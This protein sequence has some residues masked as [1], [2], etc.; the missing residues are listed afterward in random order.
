[1]KKIL[2]AVDFSNASAGVVS[3]AADMAAA[4]GAELH[5]LHVIEPEPTYTAYGFTPDEFPAIHTFH[6]ETRTRAQKTLDDTAAKVPGAITHLGDG[7]PLHVLV[8]KVEE[9]GVD[10][11]VLGSHGHGVVAALLLGSVAEGLVRKSVVPTLVVPAR[12][13]E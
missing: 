10:L 2:A 13:S 11:V 9:L 1:M 8:E 6:E 7:S 12:E 4:F 3:M 5:L